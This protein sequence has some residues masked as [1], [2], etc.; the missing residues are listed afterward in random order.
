MKKST[1]E[2]EDK[3]AI[4]LD[5]NIIGDPGVYVIYWNEKVLEAIIQERR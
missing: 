5:C 4:L 3:I 1:H 2:P